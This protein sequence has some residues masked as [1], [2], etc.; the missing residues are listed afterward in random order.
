MCILYF[1]YYSTGPVKLILAH[2]RDEQGERK[3]TLAS[4]FPFGNHIIGGRDEQEGG[5]WLAY[6]LNKQRV[7]ALTNYRYFY[8]TIT[9]PVVKTLPFFV[10]WLVLFL[11]SF[12][13][14]L[15]ALV[16][17]LISYTLLKHVSF[18]QSPSRGSLPLKA[19]ESNSAVSELLSDRMFKGVNLVTLQLKEGEDNEPSIIYMTNKAS[20]YGVPIIQE[21]TVDEWHGLANGCMDDEIGWAKISKGKEKFKEVEEELMVC[22]DSQ[23]AIEGEG[24]KVRVMRMVAETIMGDDAQVFGELCSS[25]RTGFSENMEQHLRFFHAFSLCISYFLCVP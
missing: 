9:Y 18:F 16:S 5:T 21:L 15:A 3:T 12:P 11:C 17:F 20:V 22:F 6:D 19:L 2:N 23:E 10:I 7:A 24:E 1:K 25:A 8:S 13:L 14:W 4:A